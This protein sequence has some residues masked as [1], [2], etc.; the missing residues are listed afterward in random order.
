MDSHGHLQENKN[1][2]IYKWILKK[3][4]KIL[5]LN[6]EAILIMIFVSVAIYAQLI[7]LFQQE[8]SIDTMTEIN[9]N[10]RTQL[11]R[12]IQDIYDYGIISRTATAIYILLISMLVL[13]HDNV[14]NNMYDIKKSYQ[15]STNERQLLGLISGPFLLTCIQASIGPQ[16]DIHIFGIYQDSAKV[17]QLFLRTCTVCINTYALPIVIVSIITQKVVSFFVL[18]FIYFYFYLFIYI[19]HISG[20]YGTT[21]KTYTLENFLAQQFSILFFYWYT[22]KIFL[23]TNG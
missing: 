6:L 5:R 1:I 7:D 22:V 11:R 10:I 17:L 16:R 23:T 8:Y 9:L 4:N 18:F 20:P 3:C 2:T 19:I 21:N 13:F 12:M 14:F 15:S